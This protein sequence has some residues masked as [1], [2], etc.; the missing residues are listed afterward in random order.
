MSLC[1][2]K[3]ELTRRAARTKTRPRRSVCE[4]Y[5]NATCITRIAVKFCGQHFHLKLWET[6]S[7]PVYS[8]TRYWVC[9]R[10]TGEFFFCFIT[11]CREM[12]GGVVT[13]VAV[14]Q[15][16]MAL[17]RFSY[18][19]DGE[20]INHLYSLGSTNMFAPTHTGCT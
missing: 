10:F 3:R 8:Q 20:L 12:L 6:F 2:D 4:T 7:F 5:R 18:P 9:N 1:L 15:A 14:C 17:L 13:N 16:N 19:F 11:G